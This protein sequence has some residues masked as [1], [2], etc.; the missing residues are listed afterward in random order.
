MTESDYRESIRSSNALPQVKET[1]IDIFEWLDEETGRDTSE[2]GHALS[3]I[4]AMATANSELS[5]DRQKQLLR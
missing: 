3:S 2:F 1:A 5:E 4:A